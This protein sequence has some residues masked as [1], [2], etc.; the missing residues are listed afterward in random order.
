M[1]FRNG[2]TNEL[3][4]GLSNGLT[5]GSTY[6]LTNGVTN[7]HTNG[8]TNDLA[9]GFPN[10]VTNGITNGLVNGTDEG[11]ANGSAD[12][13]TDGLPNG[14]TNGSASL[15]T[16]T[17]TPRP[18]LLV[19]SASH[20]AS[21]NHSI[22][23]YE[24][25]LLENGPSVPDLAYTLS[26]RREHMAHR[27][28]CVTDDGKPPLTVSRPAKVSK[29]IPELA[30]VFTGQGAQWPRM[31]AQLLADFPV[32][33]ESF[34]KMEYALS[35]LPTPC[36]FNLREEL[37]KPEQNSQIQS[38]TYSQPLCTALQC[39]L[40]D[41][42]HSVGLRATAVVGH[43]SGE[44]AAAYASGALT[45][46]DAIIV[47]YNRGVC[48]FAIKRSGAM[49]AIGLGRDEVGPFL[50]PGV[51]IGCEN[52]PESVTISGDV[53]A[54]DAVL[55]KVKASRPET[56][57]RRLRVDK[58]YHSREFSNTFDP[59]GSHN[60]NKPEDH[61]GD[62][63]EEHW[64][65]ISGIKPSDPVVPFFSSLYAKE[66]R[67]GSVLNHNYWRLNGENAVLFYPAMV[68]LVNSSPQPKMF[69][70]IG[71]HGALAGPLR[72]ILKTMDVPFQYA[73]TS[74]RKSNATS[75]F[76]DGLGNL[77]AKGISPNFA[78]LHHSR[79]VLTDLPTYPWNYSETS[80]FWTEPRLSKEWRLQKHPRHD[81]L[82]ARVTATSDLE[83]SWRNLLSTD[84]VPWIRDHVVQGNIVFPL[85]GFVSIAAAAVQ[86]IAEGKGAVSLRRVIVRQALVMY[87]G[88]N[89]EISTALRRVRLTDTLDSSWWEFNVSSYSQDSGTWVPHCT[90]EAQVSPSNPEP[91]IPTAATPLPRPV[92][93]GY[94][95]KIMARAGLSYG[96]EFRGLDNI[97]TDPTSNRACCSV[98][99]IARPQE[100]SYQIHPCEMDKCLQSIFL[101]VTR[102]L[103]RHFPSALVPVTID[104]ITLGKQTST[105]LLDTSAHVEAGRGDV[106]G[107]ITGYD[108]DG[109]TVLQ[110]KGLRASVL[111]AASDTQQKA[112]EGARVRWMPDIRFLDL[113]KLVRPV[114]DRHEQ[115]IQLETLSLLN[116][117]DRAVRLDL[118]HRPS[119]HLAKH[120][121]WLLKQYDAIKRGHSEVVPDCQKLAEL[122]DEDRLVAI[123]SI[124]QALSRTEVAAPA[125]AV[126]RAF[127]IVQ[128]VFDGKSGAV[129]G[130]FQDDTLADLYR[131]M[132]FGYCQDFFRCLAH[133]R[134]T[135]RILEVGAGTGGATR[136]VLNNMFS[137][138]GD[139]MYSSYTFTDISAGFFATAKE[140][141]QAKYPG[142]QYQ[143]LDISQDPV[144]QGFSEGEYD[145]I[146]AANVLHATPSLQKTLANV[147]KLLKPD[148]YMFLQE[149]S[150]Q[151]TW[152]SA[153]FGLLEGW[154][155]GEEDGRVD[156]PYINVDRW[157]QELQHAGFRGT[158][159]AA[160][161]HETPYQ[162]NVCIVSRPAQIGPTSAK[163]ITLLSHDLDT[164]TYSTAA[165]VFMS[166]GYQ[167]QPCH[168]GEQQPSGDV[169]VSLLDLEQP[170]FHEMPPERL[171]SL[172]GFFRQCK[173]THIIWATS[174][175]QVEC[176]EP[177]H[178]MTVGAIRTLRGE[179]GLPITTVE[180]DN[181]GDQ[182][183]LSLLQVLEAQQQQPASRD[184]TFA[185]HADYEY[186]YSNGLVMIPRIIPFSVTDQLLDN[187]LLGQ[188]SSEKRIELQTSDGGIDSL[189]WVATPPKPCGEFDVEID[190][191]VVGLNFKDM[192][193]AMSLVRDAKSELGLDG[194]GVV[195][196][197]GPKVTRVKPGDR[198][199]FYSGGAFTSRITIL[200]DLCVGIPERLTFEE[201][202]TMPCVFSTAIHSILNLG[203]LQKGQ[204]VLIHSACGSVGLAALQLCLLTG[205]TVYATVGTPEK[206]QYLQDKFGLPRDMIF[207]SRDTSFAVGV[208]SATN[209]RGIDLVL[210]SLSGELLH[211]SWQ[212]VAKFGRMVEIGKRDFQGYAKLDM[213]LFEGNRAFFGVDLH[214]I[215][216]EAP[217][218]LSGCVFRLL[219]PLQPVN[220][221]TNG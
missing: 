74:Q 145:L 126:G 77:Y 179:L 61:V 111:H 7:G 84:N 131:F 153:I 78:A 143:V 104:E 180:L 5:N 52:S 116:I 119:G 33:R 187:G 115:M 122:G 120:F 118:S 22:K 30:F 56:L 139:Q 162:V 70:E 158:E 202:A 43:S 140:N 3:P 220:T 161:D 47:A 51:V 183:L 204:T 92:S 221:Y 107:N 168:F 4:N 155:L 164:A 210:N 13:E 17:A 214:D 208:M 148:G 170:V 215:A 79:K 199:M 136:E 189:R 23:K 132:D 142:I 54:V 41:L 152:I 112:S 76:L 57:A 190:V 163:H 82:G 151:S 192:L 197:I 64:N 191:K 165:Q 105:L 103:G 218:I 209:G 71:P 42:V 141:L 157:N 198:V 177:H 146:I 149:V 11:S 166:Q 216:A 48:S 12:R 81:L 32:V 40:V 68:A 31:G 109:S 100:Q 171:Q 27:A 94:W 15:Q 211:T 69:L 108:D 130:L 21:L 135:M 83:P 213:S 123:R 113:G 63:P 65:A 16:I 66:L 99:Q 138:A 110:I 46:H 106:L 93:S 219:S 200:H 87:E 133:S 121:N 58:A 90:G 217:H 173:S 125:A 160:Y 49:G 72:Q 174:S 2:S 181:T 14:L 102:G 167:V 201:A 91:E 203:G 97:S 175:A 95:Y 195:R 156:E 184:A 35:T 10:G 154:W 101:A 39:A 24:R 73:S 150:L 128:D 8:L 169:V 137:G 207:S 53:E 26:A 172:Q 6:E 117:V 159:L 34:E 182:A 212:C 96:L 185:L 59:V 144:T 37:L 29:T 75:S 127:E 36:P 60:T 129:E 28:Y 176:Q 186:S 20:E 124:E 55:A 62:V 44:I 85:V 205:A 196:N 178:A 67:D 206:V 1:N 18:Q 188:D 98:S 194:A 147:K 88:K 134:P 9:S 19:F 80:K 89:V 86:Q 114:P 193:V 25:Y 50:R 45:L 38:A